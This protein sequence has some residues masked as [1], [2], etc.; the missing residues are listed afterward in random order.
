MGYYYWIEYSVGGDGMKAP[1]GWEMH[2]DDAD[3]PLRAAALTAH[4]VPQIRVVLYL[5]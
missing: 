4:L 2:N 5:L 3:E 1:F